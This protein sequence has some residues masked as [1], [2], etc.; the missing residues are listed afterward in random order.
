MDGH[1]IGNGLDCRSG[2][3][4]NVREIDRRISRPD[5][6]WQ[7][8]LLPP[9]LSCLAPQGWPSDDRGISLVFGRSMFAA[10]RRCEQR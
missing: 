8:C 9:E 4:E 10:V 2:E 1:D 6:H 7:A 3:V 5:G